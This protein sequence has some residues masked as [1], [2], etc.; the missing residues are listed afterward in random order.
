MSEKNQGEL[1]D[2]SRI[3]Y[4]DLGDLVPDTANA[5]RHSDRNV[6]EV[7]RALREFG[8]HS[9]LVVQRGTNRILVGNCRYEAME[10]LEWTKAAVYYVDDDNVQAVRRA[11][12]DNRT[13]ELAEWDDETLSRLIQG[14]G[15]EVEVPGWT[16]EEIE[17]LLGLGDL[18]E[19]IDHSEGQDD[20]TNR[21]APGHGHM[22]VSIGTL[23]ISLEYEKA[24]A[25]IDAIMDGFE[26]GEE[27]A[28]ME[29]F[30]EWLYKNRGSLSA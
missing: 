24:R 2:V 19:I 10:S 23:S 5:R 28:A 27:D 6:E 18:P 22:I 15:D 25:I 13:A 8:Q 9:P 12:S 26:E 3:E 1:L 11:L 16:N 30:C 7:A 4:V 29:R 17:A 20:R 14:L 21:T